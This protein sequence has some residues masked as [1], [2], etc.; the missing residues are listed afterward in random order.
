MKNNVVDNVHCVKI[1]LLLNQNAQEESC[2][3]D[4]TARSH[5]A[6]IYTKVND[7]FARLTACDVVRHNL[8]LRTDE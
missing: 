3:G 1:A 6:S 8:N 4:L 7:V 5:C 2:V